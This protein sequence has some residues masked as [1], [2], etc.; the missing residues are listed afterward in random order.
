[1]LR[2]K[3]TK[4]VSPS[5][6]LKRHAL[7]WQPLLVGFCGV[8]FAGVVLIGFWL[9]I[10]SGAV[11]SDS[12]TIVPAD[13]ASG[14]VLVSLRSP[15]PV[16]AEAE[17]AAQE[18]EQQ[19]AARAQTLQRVVL[20]FL[21]KYCTDCHGAESQEGDIVVHKL[22]SVDQLLD[23]RKTWQRVYRMINAGAMPPADH[24]PRPATDEQQQV[25]E[26]LYDELNNFDCALVYN[27]GR[28]A[29]QRLNRAE[30]NNTIQDLFG[31]ELTPADDFPAD[32]VGEGFDNIGDVLSLPP[33]LMEKYLN[34]AEQVA[35]AVI[36]TT[37]Y[38]R[39][40]S[41]TMAAGELQGG[42][43]SGGSRWL[44][45]NGEI[46]GTVDL[47]ATGDYEI[48]V[49]ASATQM[50]EERARFALRHGKESL[51]E[52]DV[53][54]DR[55]DETFRHRVRL[56]AGSIRLAAA[57][58]NDAYDP[59]A[60]KD[61]NF[62]VRS[63]SVHGPI[64]GGIVKY[65]EA[66]KRFVKARPGKDLDVTAAARQVLQPILD[67]AFR[68]P[69]TEDQLNRY[70]LLVRMAV[71]E[72]GE[73]YETGLFMAL[74]AMLVAPDFLFR[75]E[76]EPEPGQS[77]R[78]LDDFELASRLSYF[79]WSSMPDDELFELAERSELRKPDTL[80]QQVDRMLHDDRADAL[81]DNFAAQ[82]LNLRNL[83]DVTPD[84]DLFKS[85]N[86]EL[87]R[88]MRQETELLF[89]TVMQEDRSIEDLLSADF[90]FVNQRLAEHYGIQGIESDEFERVSLA[91]TNRSGVLTHASILTLT[92]NPN[93]T[94]PVK[95]GK[96]IMENIFGEAPP[97]PPPGVPELE[98]TAKAAP[99]ATLREQLAKHREDPGCAACH[100]LMDPLG[101]GFEN[102]NAVGR[103]RTEDE[104][105]AIDAAGSLPS[106]ESFD[107]PL[108]LI[109][110]VR[111]RRED[112]FRTMSEK[113]LVYAVGRGA[114]YY[115]KCAVDQCLELL[116]KRGNRF[117][118]LVEAIVLSDPFLK[119]RAVTTS[120]AENQPVSPAP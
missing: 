74:Q 105:R 107:G 77:E 47:P 58:L 8:M 99:D 57:F 89:R 72:L 21:N 26:F 20:P 116:H 69:V 120:A 92:S 44:P 33:L 1:M 13:E 12:Q 45:S 115:D 28:P 24:D 51:G 88:D 31:I 23:E 3:S 11:A 114:E 117:S 118:A 80:R 95:R 17:S 96:W 104:G 15:G 22:Q 79:L 29:V 10:R 9:V 61:R 37:D 86:D 4:V 97:P 82:W 41:L 2:T 84:T 30:Y 36:D 52:F 19:K 62:A 64:G 94:S 25:A 85:F 93:R 53:Q 6:E 101:L 113:M 55:T 7:N 49:V 81:V 78:R 18:R 109:S 75:L 98:E 43:M 70:A 71:D 35:D 66:H 106:G 34:A 40:L 87:K 46:F 76:S 108:Q 83:D 32:D 48:R 103:W 14:A 67:R 100:K 5:R 59:D 65:A 73:T 102:F 54:K 119:K 27:P 68:R 42:S 16:D 91:D 60:G 39:P 38:S 110:I 63:I 56:E 90:T 50:E 112:F 111:K